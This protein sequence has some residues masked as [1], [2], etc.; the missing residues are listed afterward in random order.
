M[1]NSEGPPLIGYPRQL[2]K[3]F[4]YIPLLETRWTKSENVVLRRENRTTYSKRTVDVER[5]RMSK[6]A[7]VAY[8]RAPTLYMRVGTNEM[9]GNTVRRIRLVSKFRNQNFSSAKQQ[10]WLLHYDF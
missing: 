2:I 5:Q 9:Q 8:F 6:E 3:Y 10:W 4:S 7:V 1:C